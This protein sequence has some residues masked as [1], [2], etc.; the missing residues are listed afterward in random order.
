MGMAKTM[1]EYYV[2]GPESFWTMLVRAS[3]TLINW[4]TWNFVYN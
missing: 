2:M 3:K 1:W 4:K